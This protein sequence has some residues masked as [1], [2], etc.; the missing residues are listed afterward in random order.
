M[1]VDVKSD[2]ETFG[3]HLSLK[4]FRGCVRSSKVLKNGQP[5]CEADLTDREDAEFKS[6]SNAFDTRNLKHTEVIKTWCM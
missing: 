2:V 1:L 6:N 5:H 3:C 4:L